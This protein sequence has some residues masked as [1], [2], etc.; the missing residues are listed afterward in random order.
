MWRSTCLTAVQEYASVHNI[1][2]KS[3]ST[4]KQDLSVL[5][6]DFSA[7]SAFGGHFAHR[8]HVLEGNQELS[9]EYCIFFLGLP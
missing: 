5:F 4:D 1:P 2:S 9:F 7:H 8:E 6:F 3:S